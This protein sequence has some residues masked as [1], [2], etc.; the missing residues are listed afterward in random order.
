MIDR[1]YRW[2]RASTLVLIAYAFAWFL[3]GVAISVW[4][5]WPE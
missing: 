5:A 3:G 1:A 4:R 2:V